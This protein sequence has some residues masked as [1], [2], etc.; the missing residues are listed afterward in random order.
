MPCSRLREH[1]HSN[2]SWGVLVRNHSCYSHFI[3][4]TIALGFKLFAASFFFGNAQPESKQ[5][6]ADATEVAAKAEFNDRLAE[7]GIDPNF[8][9]IPIEQIKVGMRVPARNP[10]ISDE[11]RAKFVDPDQETWR[12]LKLELEKSPVKILEIEMIRPLQWLE[13][14]NAN[15]IGDTIFL[16][17]EELGA[18][19][20]AK[21]LELGPCPTIQ[22]GPGQVVIST[23]AHPA[24]HD[25]LEVT[26]E[27][28]NG[29]AEKIRVTETHPFW[30]VDQHAFLPVG[31]IVIGSMIFSAV[32]QTKTITNI[33]PR[34]GPVQQVY[35]LEV[36]G[37]HDS[38]PFWRRFST[39]VIK[40]DIDHIIKNHVA[41]EES[42]AI[43]RRS[44][45][46][47]PTLFN[48]SKEA[49]IAELR[50]SVGQKGFAKFIED[51]LQRGLTGRHPYETTFG[52]QRMRIWVNFGRAKLLVPL[53][54]KYFMPSVILMLVFL[55]HGNRVF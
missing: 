43:L 7:Q 51:G 38:Q 40:V 14:H 13:K 8:T 55:E 2:W 21:I 19:G 39:N 27:D 31:R 6:V 32:D 42:L 47:A 20:H 34:R 16:D 10:E 1:A 23:F 12:F 53:L 29:Q 22:P 48:G 44:R 49:Y 5:V 11:E 50:K 9:H 25:I 36:N 54:L 37:E 35:N 3:S 41:G 45:R 33:L 52:R 28:E 30:S 46:D 24:S 15:Q 26:F 18:R 4:R 17:M